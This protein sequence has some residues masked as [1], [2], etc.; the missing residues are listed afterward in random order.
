MPAFRPRDQGGA[1]LD[2]ALELAEDIAQI[3]GVDEVVVI[4]G[5]EIYRAAMPRADRLYMTEVH[6]SVEGDAVL[7]EIDWA[8]WREV[9]RERHAAE[10]P[11]PYDYSFV[12]YDA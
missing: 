10:A 11:N 7:P 12:V 4:G 1:S 3:D 5:A 8:Q 9:G 6:A 2:E